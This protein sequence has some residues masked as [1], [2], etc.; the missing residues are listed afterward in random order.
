MVGLFSPQ[1]ARLTPGKVCRTCGRVAVPG[2][3]ETTA[4]RLCKSTAE[5]TLTLPCSDRR[6]A[7]L[8]NASPEGLCIYASIRMETRDFSKTLLGY[9]QIVLCF[10]SHGSE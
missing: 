10:P 8:H 7:L 9:T 6:W 3:A 4:S 5:N 1:H 2:D